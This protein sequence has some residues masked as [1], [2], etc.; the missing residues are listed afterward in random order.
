ML[1]EIEHLRGKVTG[2]QLEDIK[3]V[4]DGNQDV[5]SRHKRTSGAVVLLNME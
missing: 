5:F 2:E 4:L 1:P 3:D